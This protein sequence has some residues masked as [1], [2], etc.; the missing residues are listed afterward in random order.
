[1]PTEVTAQ[2][3]PPQQVHTVKGDALHAGKNVGE[4]PCPVRL[5]PWLHH[6]PE[7]AS[8]TSEGITALRT[9]VIRLRRIAEQIRQHAHHIRKSQEIA[10]PAIVRVGEFAIPVHIPCQRIAAIQRLLPV[11]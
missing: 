10:P 11:C 7:I 5:W 1:M 3:C 4:H 9:L 6:R 8:R 2:A